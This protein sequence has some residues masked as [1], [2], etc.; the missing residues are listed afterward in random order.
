MDSY[1]QLRLDCIGSCI[2]LMV[3]GDVEPASGIVDD[4]RFG[5]C[6][7]H[8]IQNMKQVTLCVSLLIVLQRCC[9]GQTTTG[10]LNAKPTP[11]ISR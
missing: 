8:D 9:V 1:L 4:A 7:W 2:A 11:A 10:R 3:A 5:I 6:A